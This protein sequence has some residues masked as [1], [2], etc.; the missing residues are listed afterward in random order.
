MGTV[1]DEKGGNYY[2]GKVIARGEGDYLEDSETNLLDACK[3]IAEVIGPDAAEH[4]K[5]YTG[6]YPS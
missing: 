2:F 6:T 3:G 4:I 1:V 5:L